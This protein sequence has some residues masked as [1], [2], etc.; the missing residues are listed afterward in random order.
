[1][2]TTDVSE[3]EGAGY[4]LAIELSATARYRSGLSLG[5]KVR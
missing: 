4:P 1:V 3:R 2:H 5:A